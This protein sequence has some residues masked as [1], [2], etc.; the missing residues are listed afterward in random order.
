[1]LATGATA[2]LA[3]LGWVQLH[4][5]FPVPDVGHP[6]LIVLAAAAGWLAALIG[7]GWLVQL[8]YAAQ[9]R[10]P[11]TTDLERLG[12]YGGLDGD[13][14]AMRRAVFE[15]AAEEHGRSS[16]RRV[17]LDARRLECEADRA[18]GPEKQRKQARADRLNDAI[19]AA[20]VGAAGLILERRAAAV[21]KSNKAKLAYVLAV[22]GIVLAYGAADYSKG[23]RDLVGVRKACAEAVKVGA[24]NACES[25]ADLEVA[26]ADGS[27]NAGTPA[28][29]V[30]KIDVGVTGGPRRC[31]AVVR[32]DGK[33]TNG[34]RAGEVE[35]TIRD[36]SRHCGLRI[37]GGGLAF[38]SPR[39]HTGV[40]TSNARL[41]PISYGV[42]L[43]LGSG[44][45]SGSAQGQREEKLTDLV[46]VP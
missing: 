4:N 21:F 20:V 23:Q 8:L 40:T 32:V 41:K 18:E 44:G 39:R 19:D 6:W 30:P 28:A 26:A 7:A 45:S 13:E 5:V 37:S 46:A 16:L 11:I 33:R 34:T 22:V 43:F 14:I 36:R 24:A 35:L 12:P 15:S 42:V 10:I 3:G 27:D 38:E 29:E 1:V 2:V 25:V 31:R 9:R 17:E